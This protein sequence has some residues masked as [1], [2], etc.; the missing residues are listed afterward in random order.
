MNQPF[1]WP[2]AFAAQA[3]AD[4]AI[5]EHLSSMDV[6]QCQKLHFLQMTC[7]KLAKAFLL[8]ERNPS[9]SLHTS[10]A[11]IAKP[12]P[13][14]LEHF[15]DRISKSDQKHFR[16]LAREIELL[17]PSVDDNGKRPDNCEYPWMDASGQIRVP[18]EHAFVVIVDLVTQPAG[19]HFIKLV[20]N[21]IRELLATPEQC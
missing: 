1:D 16:F 5:W 18:A 10:H 9:P 2:S 8:K 21:C 14:I 12:L 15:Q 7:E 4:L 13:R 6:P 11:Y 20:K 17:A 19:R 3:Q